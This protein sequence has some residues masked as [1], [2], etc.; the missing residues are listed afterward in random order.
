MISARPYSAESKDLIQIQTDL[1]DPSLITLPDLMKYANGSNPEVPPFLALLEMNRRKHIQET[2]K[3]FSSPEGTIKDQTIGALLGEPAANPTQT[4]AG[5]NPAAAQPMVNPAA[6]QPMMNPGAAPPMVDPTQM[7]QQ[8]NPTMRAAQG[9]IMSLPVN[10][11]KSQNYAGGGIV[12]FGDPDLN[13]SETQLVR[14]N[15]EDELVEVSPGQYKRKSELPQPR[16]GFKLGDM[17]I[18]PGRTTDEVLKSLPG[19]TPLSMERPEKYTLQQLSDRQKEIDRLAGVSA[20]PYKEV[21]DQIKSMEDRQKSQYKDAA[22]DRLIAQLEAFGTA[23]PSQGFAYGMGASSKASRELQKEQNRLRDEQEKVILD[24]R[25]NL[26]KDEDARA[27]GNATAITAAEAAMQKNQFDYANLEK[28]QQDLG[29]RQLQA[30][31]TM[32]G[33][34]ATQ[35][36]LPIDVYSAE[37][38]RLRDAE[39]KRHNKELERLTGIRDSNKEDPQDKL[40]NK[41]D[42]LIL[43]DDEYRTQAALIKSGAITIG[44]P[45][46]DKAMEIMDAV[47]QR[48]YKSRGLMDYYVPREKPLEP[49]KPKEEPGFFQ[50]LKNLFPG[51][52]TPSASAPKAVPFNSLPKN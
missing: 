44:T 35:A 38:Q 25:K 10:M 2:S 18:N 23:D 20:D 39:A 37:S 36:K 3:E 5:V 21:K 33:T 27:K 34:E 31:A 47:R 30:A 1:Q 51:S 4:P 32:A 16:P 11:F 42:Q 43:R 26:A 29:L 50:G 46:Y 22:Y 7:Q 17:T 41:V 9:G 19:I 24:Y 52:S 48:Y 15:Q 8:V 12:A 28:Q 14:G 45:D 6:A 49:P 13:T 40:L